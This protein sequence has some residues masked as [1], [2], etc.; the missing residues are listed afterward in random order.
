MF[1]VVGGN[2]EEGSQVVELAFGE[3]D[4]AVEIGHNA[5]SGDSIAGDEGNHPSLYRLK[6]FC[7]EL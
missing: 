5:A 7:D 6:T 2:I 1:K 4:K 3:F